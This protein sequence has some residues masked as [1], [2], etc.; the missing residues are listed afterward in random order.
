MTYAEIFI[1]EKLCLKK[2]YVKNVYNMCVAID[3]KAF[4]KISFWFRYFHQELYFLLLKLL[5]ELYHFDQ[6]NH[7]HNG[8]GHLHK[9]QKL[10]LIFSPN[11][12][13][14][15]TLWQW[16]ISVGHDTNLFYVLLPT[17]SCEVGKWECDNK[18]CIRTGYKC[19][20]DNDCGD[21][22]DENDCEYKHFGTKQFWIN[23]GIWFSLENI[24]II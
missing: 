20:G 24:R 10:L 13:V 9:I 7:Y 8:I 2:L 12:R 23:K 21:N 19:D 14:H 16:K 1:L 6:F 18:N 22:S 3:M 5:L 17:G 11:N 15:K 4:V